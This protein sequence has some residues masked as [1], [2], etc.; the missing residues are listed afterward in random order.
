[1]RVCISNRV[2][3]DA[4]VA[5]LRTSSADN[6]WGLARDENSGAPPRTPEAGARGAGPTD[7]P[8]DS[9]ALASLSIAGSRLCLVQEPPLL[10]PLHM[11]MS[12]NKNVRP[13]ESV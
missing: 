12:L 10:P 8:A 2:P 6:L 7:P 11:M 1:M 13:A 4:E 3:G 9:D 5:G